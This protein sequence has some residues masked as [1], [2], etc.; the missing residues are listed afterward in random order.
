MRE[1]QQRGKSR[2]V[3]K[4]YT[5][6]EGDSLYQ[7][8]KKLGTVPEGIYILNHLKS[9][10]LEIGQKL[11]IPSYVEAQV[12][13]EDTPVYRWESTEGES[14]GELDAGCRLEVVGTTQNFLAVRYLRQKG[15]L[16]RQDAQLIAYGAQLP[17]IGVLGYYMEEERGGFPSSEE[18]FDAGNDVLTS[19]ALFFW[20]LDPGNPGL[21]ENNADASPEEILKRVRK[22]HRNNVQMLSVVQNLTYPEADLAGQTVQ[23]VLVDEGHRRALVT[24]ILSLITEY[25]MDGVNLD[26][27]EIAAEDE[28]KYHDFLEELAGALHEAGYSLSVCVPAREADEEE[29]TEAFNYRRIAET[30]DHMV[31][32]MYNEHGWPGSG[33]GPVSSTPWMEA[34]L[35]Y[36]LQQA[37]PQKIVAAVGLFGFDFNVTTGRVRYISHAQAM[38]LA[39]QYHAQPRYD[40]EKQSWMF[41]YQGVGGEVHEV[42]Y[43]DERS[44]EERAY[45]ASRYGIWG[46]GLWRLGLGDPDLW[47]M[48]R[49]QTV[50]RKE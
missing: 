31:I 38:R 45:T 27:E 6:R 10:R 47:Q 44:I 8:G 13:Y 43:D 12:L 28:E 21:L 37:E 14:L 9:D 24:S 2:M 20:R 41:E 5:V 17:V 39:E 40:R 30:V 23:L 25:G 34:V 7:I 19:C 46:L 36:A 11:W 32:M 4:Q 42:W 48:L 18:A 3:E 33:S 16:R 35:D 15:Y 1:K 26:L 49:T 22:G 50:V 29:G